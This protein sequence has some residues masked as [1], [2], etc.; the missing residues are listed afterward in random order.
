MNKD[1]DVF[2]EVLKDVFYI[3]TII[4]MI[5]ETYQKMIIILKKK[6]S[7]YNDKRVIK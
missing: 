6:L 1:Y 3:W 2:L 4:Y 7:T 5:Y